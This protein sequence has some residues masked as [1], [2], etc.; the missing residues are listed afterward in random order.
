MIG[1]HWTRNNE[2]RV[3]SLAAEHRPG[4]IMATVLPGDNCR[5]FSPLDAAH[6]RPSLAG[7]VARLFPLCVFVTTTDLLVLDF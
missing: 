7:A 5:V 4:L 1:T 3:S 2:R 6:R